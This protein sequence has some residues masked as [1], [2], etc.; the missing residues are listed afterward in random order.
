MELFPEFQDKIKNF[1]LAPLADRMRPRKLK[2][3]LGQTKLM[4]EGKP[5]RI[6]ITEKTNFSF[7]LWGPP[8]SGKTTIARLVSRMSENEFHEISAVNAGVSEIRKVIHQAKKTWSLSRRGSILFVDEI[9]RLNKA[10]QDSVLPHIENGTIRLIGSTTENPS[11]EVIP[12]LRSRC[13][14]FRLES[15]SE[16]DIRSLLERGL[17][18]KEYGLGNDS[19]EIDSDAL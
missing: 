3:L 9:H 18:D 15:L 19:I 16:N 6:L 12:S 13:Q 5:L 1:P 4:G 14:I 8:G 11:F 17:F 10:Q 7:I 2:D